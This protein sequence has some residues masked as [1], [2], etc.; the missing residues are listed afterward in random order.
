MSALAV[1]YN[2]DPSLYRALES[3]QNV[4]CSTKPKEILTDEDIAMLTSLKLDFEHGGIRLSAS[5]RQRVATLQNETQLLGAQFCR[6]IADTKVFVEADQSKLEVLPGRILNQLQPSP[7]KAGAVMIPVGAST[8]SQSIMCSVKDSDVRRAIYMADLSRCSEKNLPILDKLL[9]VRFN[10]AK[11]LGFRSYAHSVFQGRIASSP[12]AVLSF[13]RSLSSVLKLPA[14]LELMSLSKYL[15]PVDDN[16]FLRSANSPE[17]VR[18]MGWDRPYLMGVAR[19]SEFELDGTDISAY[20]SLTTCLEGI[21]SLLQHVFGIRMLEVPFSECEHE[22]WHED[23]KKYEIRDQNDDVLGHIFLDLLYREGKFSHGAHFCIRCGRGNGNEEPHQTPVVAVVCN[24]SRQNGSGPLLL[25]FSEYEML[26][27]EFGHVLHSLLSQTRYQHLS[28]TRVVTDL[29]EI[30]SH[31]FEHFAWDPR[32][33]LHA[34]RHYKSGAVLPNRLIHALSHSRN[35]F[36]ATD[37]KKQIF[38]ACLDLELHAENPAVP[39]ST[40]VVSSLQENIAGIPHVPGTAFQA[41]FQHIIGYGGGYYSC[42]FSAM[43]CSRP[44]LTKNPVHSAFLNVVT[45][46]NF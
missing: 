37:M 32:I 23:V 5:D 7:S 35:R 28:G 29:V 14:E 17:S 44:F 12:T 25:Q 16:L 15:H 26:W 46:H 11:L 10:T 21:A 19:A 33:L 38:Y 9:R 39:S 45:D 8:L 3:L 18:Y 41:S 22:L 42:T 34:M 36:L 6:N 40:Q 2:A 30:P 31:L 27:H 13:L 20:F 1:A 4:T 43:N 24:F